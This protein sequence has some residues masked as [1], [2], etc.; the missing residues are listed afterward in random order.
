MQLTI[1]DF[2]LEQSS[3]CHYDSV[4]VYADND[5]VA[6]LCGEQR[7]NVTY[8]AVKKIMITFKTDGSE[9][10][11]GFRASFRNGNIFRLQYLNCKKCIPNLRLITVYTKEYH[12]LNLFKS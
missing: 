10:F 5:R 9:E 12:N 8:N 6:I 1:T 7:E 4:R 3:G 2:Q 11:R